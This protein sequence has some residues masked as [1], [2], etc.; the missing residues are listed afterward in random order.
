M[1]QLAQPALGVQS[2]SAM[3]LPPKPILIRI[4]L[5]GGLISYV[6][7]E[8]YDR[9][10]RQ[11][12]AE[13]AAEAAK[14]ADPFKP[15]SSIRLEDGTQ[16]PVLELTES[17]FEQ[18]FG[19]KPAETALSAEELEK[20]LNEAARAGTGPESAAPPSA[21]QT[22][23]APTDAPAPGDVVPAPPKSAGDI[24]EQPAN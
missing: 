7:W 24:I 15:N 4:V 22:E 23:R 16:M 11:S 14:A 6:G 17:E 9:H 10:V 3:A 1:A 12:E 5:W 19:H 21:T 20:A 2:A 13:A 8:A 18:R